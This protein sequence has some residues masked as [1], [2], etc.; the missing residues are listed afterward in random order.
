M[1]KRHAFDTWFRVSSFRF[2]VLGLGFGFGVLGFG[3]EIWGLG[4]GVWGLGCRGSMFGVW[5]LGSADH[6]VVRGGRG[7]VL[8]LHRLCGSWVLGVGSWG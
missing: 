7:H 2:G 5:G 6:D 3:F 8:A 1:P 4:F